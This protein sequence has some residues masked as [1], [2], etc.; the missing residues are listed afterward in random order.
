MSGD[1]LADLLQIASRL[2][3]YTGILGVIGV[4]AFRLLI[5][6]LSLQPSPD[7]PRA[8]ATVGLT[9]AAVLAVGTLARLYAQTYASFGLEEPVTLELLRVIATALPPWST[10]WLLQAGAALM[11]IAAFAA[12]RGGA[13][14]GWTA[15]HAGAIA[16]GVTAPLTGHAVSQPGGTAL[17]LALQALHVLGAGVW[18]GGLFVVFVLGVRRR[19]IVPSERLPALVNAFSPVALTAAELITA[20][21]LFTSGL[22]LHAV[23]DLWATGY[24]RTLAAKLAVVAA[25]A[26]RG[27]V[28]WRRVRPRLGE[29]GANDVLRRSAALELLFAAAVLALTAVLV[30]LPQPGE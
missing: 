10:G 6:A 4:S 14:W 3:W 29:P 7:L 15:A 24:G 5:P 28:N 2:I 9:A 12:A 30:G 11:A 27:F 26:A 1:A 23:S 13:S 19:A 20:T 17:P 25:V 16:I 22:Y 8:A 21:G 18:I